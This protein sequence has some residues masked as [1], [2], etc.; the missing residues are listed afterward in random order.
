M[1]DPLCLE[2][3]FE[4]L[5]RISPVFNEDKIQEQ[6]GN[7][8]FSNAKMM[9]LK[10]SVSLISDLWNK[11]QMFLGHEFIGKKAWLSRDSVFEF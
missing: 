7:T 6:M 2:D 11:L 1:N 3:S 4:I 5:A 9:N 10:V 8:L